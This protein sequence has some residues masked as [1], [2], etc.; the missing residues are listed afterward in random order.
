MKELAVINFSGGI[1]DV[2][3]PHLIPIEMSTDLLNA[4]VSN[5]AVISLRGLTQTDVDPNSE[6]I[7]QNGDRQITEWGNRFYWSDN[8]TGKLNSSLGYYGVPS[9]DLKPNI[10]PGEA[11][12]RFITDKVYSYA[13]SYLTSDGFE[14]S[15]NP[16]LINT[17]KPSTDLGELVIS[18]FGNPPE[19]VTG[20]VVYR[21]LA[22]GAVFYRVGSKSLFDKELDDTFIFEDDVSD[23]SLL[24]RP[25][26]DLTNLTEA[27]TDGKYLVEKNSVFYVAVGPFVRFS[28][29]NDPMAYP[30]VN[31]ITFDDDI[32]GMLAFDEYVFVA[33]KNRTYIILGDTF[34]DIVKR[35]L[36]ESQGV[37]NWRTIGRIRNSPVWLSND[38]LCAY[39]QYDNRSGR[40]IS[41]ISE[42]LKIIPKGSKS[43]VVADDSYYLLFDDYALCF[44]FTR[45]LK[46]YR[47]EWVGDWGWYDKDAD[48]LILKQ[49]EAYFS[50]NTG[51]ELEFTYLSPEFTFGDMQNLKQIGRIHVDSNCD[52]K[53]EYY[54]D[55][56]LTSSYK[57]IKGDHDQRRFYV[58]PGWTGRRLQVKISGVGELR[59]IKTEYII[60][61][62]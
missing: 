17:Y 50:A 57:S 11:G 2:I 15:L 6:L 53:L 51:D 14:G 48:L 19:Y 47:V 22:D 61:K 38:G 34:E 10:S 27:I 39:Q 41:I 26:V 56:V 1:N 18:N 35:E 46:V 25:Q 29:V 23:G 20:V 40:K 59:G 36:P 44:D 24:L 12:G 60:R 45:G 52:L 54:A 49:G 8:E 4:D 31:S 42:D 32:T 28:N 5:G 13:Y 30:A 43:A 37:K 62:S 9:T 16:N 21:T 58:P 7:Y 55:G 33:T 3:E